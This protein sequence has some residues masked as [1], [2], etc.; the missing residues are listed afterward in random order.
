MNKLQVTSLPDCD[1]CGKKESA[2]YDSPTVVGP[3]A[4]MCPEC[5]KA[6]GTGTVGTERVLKMIP[7]SDTQDKVVNGIEDDSMEYMEAVIM[8]D[9]HRCI[10]CPECGF[11]RHVEPDADYTYECECGVKVKVPCFMGVF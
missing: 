4:N 2:V 6:K 9:E 1:L 3:W 8:Q 10:E 11:V 5:F 7:K